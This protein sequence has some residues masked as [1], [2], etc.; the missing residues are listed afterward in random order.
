MEVS[1]AVDGEGDDG[2][3]GGRAGDK[4]D[5]LVAIVGM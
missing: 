2:Q 5:L 1:N 4:R 3:C